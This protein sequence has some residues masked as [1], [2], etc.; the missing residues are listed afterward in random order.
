MSVL[1]SLEYFICGA[2]DH[3]DLQSA[4]RDADLAWRTGSVLQC[5][6]CDEEVSAG[7][8]CDVRGRGRDFS[9]IDG[10]LESGEGKSGYDQGYRIPGEWNLSAEPA[11]PGHG[12]E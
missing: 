10:I 1:L 9:G 7:D 11:A 2:A 5:G 6:F 12:S 4:A 8:R 3:R